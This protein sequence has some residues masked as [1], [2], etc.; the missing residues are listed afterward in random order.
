MCLIAGI[1]MAAYVVWR[2]ANSP[3]IYSRGKTPLSQSPVSAFT[4]WSRWFLDP[5]AGGW[6]SCSS[7]DRK[8]WSRSLPT[9]R[10]HEALGF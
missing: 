2:A 8:P 1:S 10:G 6:G 4:P 7:G 5:V 9:G 3:V